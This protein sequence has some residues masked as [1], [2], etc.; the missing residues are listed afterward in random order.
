MYWRARGNNILPYL[1]DF[2]FF[3]MGYDAGCL[4]VKIVEEDMRRVGLTINLDKSD[5]AP[6]HERLH[7]GF[8]VNLAAGLFKLPIAR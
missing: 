5:G 4:L 2:L 8:D 7:L 1:D 6:K 3:I